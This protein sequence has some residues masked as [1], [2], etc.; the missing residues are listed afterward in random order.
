MAKGKK[1][2]NYEILKVHFKISSKIWYNHEN[3]TYFCFG[4]LKMYFKK[5]HVKI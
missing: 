1:Q 4:L 2:I 3:H 5:L